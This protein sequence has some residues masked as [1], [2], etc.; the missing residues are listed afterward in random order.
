VTLNIYLTATE[1]CYQ[2]I[3]NKA[4]Q[5]TC[6]HPLDTTLLME[7]T[8]RVATAMQPS[9]VALIHYTVV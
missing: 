3:N 2:S 1:H 7:G 5:H 4:P 6:G 9:R 8:L